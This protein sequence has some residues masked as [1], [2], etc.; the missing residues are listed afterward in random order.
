MGEPVG[1]RIF[2]TGGARSG[3]SRYAEGLLA[4]VDD[5]VYVAAGGPRTGDPDWDR[6]VEA[7]R[8]RRPASWTTVEDTDV[9]GILRS[10]RRPVLVDCLGTWLT[11]RIDH[12][13]AWENVELDAV[14]AEVDDLLD[15]WRTCTV[16]AIAVSNEVGSGVVP[17][18]PEER[19]WREAVGRVG[20]RIAAEADEVYR[21]VAGIVQRIK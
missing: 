4:G 6:R 18:D 20:C 10:A 7:H 13:N 17:L 3:K 16:P 12:H 15:A 19:A 2:I 9:A 8:D 14:R 21:V 5:V 1:H 11:A